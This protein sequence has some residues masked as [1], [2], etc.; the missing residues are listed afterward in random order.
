MPSI[1]LVHLPLDFM[2]SRGVVLCLVG[3]MS[4]TL[5]DPIDCSP[6]GSSVHGGSPG[7]NTGVACRAFL[8]EIFPTQGL[9]P[10]LPHCRWIRYHLSHQGSPRILEWVAY[11][12]FRGIF[13]TQESNLDLMYC[14]WILY[15]LSYQGSARHSSCFTSIIR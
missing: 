9:N 1:C 6:P 13:L 10:G 15:Q 2:Q 4:L 11:P 7:K 5:C 14:R 12:F 8:Q 3:Q